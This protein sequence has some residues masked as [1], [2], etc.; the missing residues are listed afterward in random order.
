MNGQIDKTVRIT[1][2]T[3]WSCHRVRSLCLCSTIKTFEIEP[4]IAILIHPKEYRRTVGT[5]R[6]VK[7]SILNSRL[8]MGYGK[9]FDQN[10]SLLDVILDPAIYPMVLYPGEN[11]VN[12]SSSTRAE[13]TE[14]IPEGR[15]LAIFVIDGTWSNAHRMIRDSKILSSLPKISFDIRT[16]SQYG[17]RKQPQAFCLSTVEAVCELIENLAQKGLCEEPQEKAHDQMLNGFRVLVKSQTGRNGNFT[18]MPEPEHKK[19]LAQAEK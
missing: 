17:F 3:C 2:E 8:W 16:T 7:L 12:L 5:A 6:L 10:Q 1:R 15:R 18:R 9:D 11:S 19:T 14:K 4:L 13:L